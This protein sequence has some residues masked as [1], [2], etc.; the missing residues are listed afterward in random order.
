MQK[1]KIFDCFIFFNEL[2]LLELRLME[3][4]DTVDYFVISE[5][6]TTHTGKPKEF[7]FEKNKARYEKYLDKIIYI[8]V[9]DCPDFSPENPYGIEH[10]QRNALTRG[11]EGK[12]NM[13]D[14]IL[15]SDL[16]EIPSVEAIKANLE[17]KEWIYLQ[18]DLFY[19]Y[20]NCQV[21]R[22]CGGPVMADYGTFKTMRQLRG[23]A[24]KRYNFLPEKHKEVYP[25]AGWHYSYLTGNDPE[26]IKY[27][28][29]SIAEAT[30]IL[31]KLGSLSDISKKVI[32]HKD[33]F[34]RPSIKQ[35]QQIVDISKNKPRALDEFL[36]KYPQF[37]YNDNSM[38][39]RWDKW[40]KDVTKRGPFKYGNTL[41][42]RLAG[43]FLKDMGTV[44][45]WGCGT[46]AFKD[47]YTG[48]YVG[49]DGSKNPFVNKVVDL[50]EYKSDPDGIIMRHILEHNYDWRKIL[51]NALSSFKK[52]FCL[53]LFT[54]FV[55]KTGV[56]AQNKK[57]G[58]DVPDIAFKR[59]DVES[60]L[61][62][63]KWRMESHRTRT[64]YRIEHIYYIERSQVQ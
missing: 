55:D 53:V 49:V 36:K 40:Y 13:G 1:P 34:E 6:N 39:G 28:V 17:R 7:I 20:V 35:E 42:Y 59:E 10:F 27:K 54:P 22:S 56:I 11:L 21:T 19:Y 60:K 16:D 44:E 43:E 8:K 31:D 30:N 18:C 33:L 14:K 52:K 63:L 2:E 9:T 48:R 64:Q 50:R 41:T 4:S 47:F 46:G 3:L 58:V 37:F 23:F 51:D 12:A 26:K 61:K 29:E 32:N 24:R 45:D 25:H 57:Y 5:A 38:L 15:V 62:G